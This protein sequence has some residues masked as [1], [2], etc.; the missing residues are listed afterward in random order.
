MDGKLGEIAENT[1]IT[2]VKTGLIDL[3]LQEID[4]TLS[5]PLT[6]VQKGRFDLEAAQS[7]LDSMK[8]QYN[9]K[10]GS[11]KAEAS[12]LIQKLNAGGG[13]FNSCHDVTSMN[14]KVES[15]C[16]DRFSD[17]MMP[18]SNGILF[19]LTKWYKSRHVVNQEFV[20]LGKPKKTFHQFPDRLMKA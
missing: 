17:E 4:K 5:T 20:F 8:E 16:L 10:V 18:L 14:G 2:A 9:A 1:G 15:R 13:G 7:D 3:T 19:F 12:N 6:V 11:I